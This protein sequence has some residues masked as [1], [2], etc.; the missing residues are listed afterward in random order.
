MKDGKRKKTLQ[1]LLDQIYNDLHLFVWVADDGCEMWNGKANPSYRLHINNFTE[2]EAKI[3]QQWFK[4]KYGIEPRITMWKGGSGN[5]SPVLMFRVKEAQVIWNRI[6][7]YV[8]QID[9]MKHKFRGSIAMW[10]NCIKD[11]NR[12]LEESKDEKTVQIG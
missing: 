12:S 5:L 7:P 2:G 11:V 8:M 3:A 10:N 9:S 4:V 1:W 6:S